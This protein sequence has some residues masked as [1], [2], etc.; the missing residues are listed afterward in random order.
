MVDVVPNFSVFIQ[1]I[2]FL[3]LM[4]VLNLLLYKPIRG[5]IKERREKIAGLNGDIATSSEGVK[6]KQDEMNSLRNE[7]K[8]QGAAARE[9]IKHEGRSEERK[10][11]DEATAQMEA[12]V[13]EVR[14][15]I[16]VEMSTAREELRGQ[17]Q[18]FGAELAQKL[19]GRSIQ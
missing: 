6:S 18:V 14:K 5:I 8:K 17:V 12:A 13:E 7:A 3:V 19:L 16:A 9:E 2:N 15:Q 10:L 1:I 4:Y 11:V